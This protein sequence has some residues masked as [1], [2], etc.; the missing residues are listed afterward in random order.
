MKGR[1]TGTLLVGRYRVDA[2]VAAGGSSEVYSAE[3]LQLGVR[4]ALKVLRRDAATDPALDAEQE[5]SFRRERAVLLALRHPNIVSV[6]DSGVLESELGGAPY[7]VL[8]WCEGVRLSTLL[9]AAER[10]PMTPEQA[11]TAL[12]PIVDA[13]AHAHERGVVLGELTARAIL[14]V[15]SSELR[16]PKLFDFSCA[17]QVG[18]SPPQGRSAE[19][20]FAADV[21]ALGLLYLALLASAIPNDTEDPLATSD[22]ARPS[23]RILRANAGPFDTVIARALAREPS[24][25][26]RDARAFQRAMRAARETSTDGTLRGIVDDARAPAPQ[27]AASSSRRRWLFA[28]GSL[29]VVATLA[30]AAVW[31]ISRATEEAG[32]TGAD[33]LSALDSTAVEARLSALG[34]RV[35]SASDGDDTVTVTALTPGKV[36][37]SIVLLPAPACPPGRT[38]AACEPAVRDAII[39]DQRLAGGDVVAYASGGK[40]VLIVRSESAGEAER[41]RDGIIDGLAVGQIGIVHAGEVPSDEGHRATTLAGLGPGELTAQLEAAGFQVT[42]AGRS[43]DAIHATAIFKHATKTSA[44]D[45]YSTAYVYKGDVSAIVASIESQPEPYAWAHAG[46]YVIVLRGDA[47]LSNRDVLAS[48]IRGLGATIG[49]SRP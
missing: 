41:V 40:R 14:V 25:R 28:G 44:A 16:N 39:R 42:W 20:T 11:W 4:V 12:L 47:S 26:F 34:L 17:R 6:L 46:S 15:P 43:G 48:V 49:G 7:L 3:H 33:P 10:P 27:R 5:L 9:G 45:V 23:P 1:L 18:E 2:L 21:H 36:A 22:P 37:V 19:L 38:A 24:V 32:P 29:A 31:Q 13:V 35:A 8:A 30:A